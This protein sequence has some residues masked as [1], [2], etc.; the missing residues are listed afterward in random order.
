MISLD[1]LVRMTAAIM[2]SSVII[3]A[4]YRTYIRYSSHVISAIEQPQPKM[5]EDIHSSAVLQQ[6]N[7]SDMTQCKFLKNV[8][9]MKIHKCGSS[10]TQNIFLRFGHVHNLLVALPKGQDKPQIGRF[11]KITE[12][13]YEAPPSGLRW[14]VFAHHA[15]YHRAGILRLMPKNT[16]FVAI[17]REPVSRFLSAFIYF[18]MAKYFPGMIGSPRLLG[19]RRRL[20]IPDRFKKP[21]NRGQTV[22]QKITVS[23]QRI[24]TKNS[25]ILQ[26]LQNPTRWD[27]VYRPPG[28]RDPNYEHACVRNCMVRDLGFPESLYENSTAIHDFVEGIERDFTLVMILQYFDQSLVLLKRKMCWSIRDILYDHRHRTK[29]AK[30]TKPNITDD[31]K[32]TFLKHNE[33]DAVLY[34]YFNDSLWKQI[35]QEGDDFQAEVRH[36][37]QVNIGATKYC[38]NKSRPREFLVANSTWN[39]KFE[40]TPHFCSMLG[41]KRQTWDEILRSRY[42]N[43]SKTVEIEAKASPRHRGAYSRRVKMYKKNASLVHN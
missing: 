18:D 38:S 16:K 31:M 13:D 43:S 20:N 22:G 12:H 6:R 9:F 8:A 11:G 28:P 2:V 3:L 24:H 15:V 21:R 39:E 26:Y 30:A 37:Q 41:R 10:T 23:H 32:R 5:K 42:R 40:I 25:S 4:Y 35:A 34:Q 33:A 29:K 14:N 7:S 19:P 1:F 36:F 17:L 27:N